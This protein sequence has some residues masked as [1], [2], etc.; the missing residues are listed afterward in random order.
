MVQHLGGLPGA[1]VEIHLEIQARLPEG[2]TE[3]TVRIVTENCRTL[4]FREHRFEE[5]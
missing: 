1:A 2:A 3:S 5:G 4:K